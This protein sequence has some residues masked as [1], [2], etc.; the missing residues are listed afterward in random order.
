MPQV[1]PGKPEQPGCASVRRSPQ[2]GKI[3]ALWPLH[4]RQTLTGAGAVVVNCALPLDD[5]L[6]LVKVVP[7]SV[8]ENGSAMVVTRSFE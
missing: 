4:G 7:Y 5:R 2:Y 8:Y 6:M 1:P 3:V